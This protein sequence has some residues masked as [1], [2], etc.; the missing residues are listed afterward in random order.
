MGK[1]RVK[2]K[3]AIHS[4]IKVT[5]AIALT[6]TAVN[7]LDKMAKELGLS[8]SELIEQIARGEL[9]REAPEKKPLWFWIYCLSG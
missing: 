1:K 7:R 9:K 5:R 2:G 4:E 8:R 3:P 6:D